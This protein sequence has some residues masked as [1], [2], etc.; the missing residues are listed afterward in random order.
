M[1]PRNLLKYNNKSRI[2]TIGELLVEFVPCNPDGK[3]SQPGE[4]IKTASGSSGIFASA[5]G[6]LGNESGFIGQI[7]KDLLSQFVINVVKKQGV[8][9]QH[10]KV[11]DEGKIG[12]SFVEY[13]ESGRNFQ[14]YRDNSVGSQLDEDGVDAE[15]ISNSAILHYPGMLLELSQSMQ[16]ACIKAV[17]IAKENGVIV[18]FDPNIRKELIQKDGAIDRMKWAVAQADIL[19]PT[20]EEAKFITG[21]EDISKIIR[22]LHAMGPK[23]IAITKDEDGSIISCEDECLDFSGYSIDVIDPTGAG[24]TFSAALLVGIMKEWDLKKIG[25]FA[26][27]AGALVCKKQ[28]T[29]GLA[30]PTYEDTIK[31]MNSNEC[32]TEKI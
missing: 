14:Y 13:T 3:L 11:V 10:I 5:V 6:K 2:I 1:I 25:K 22:K 20:L 24:D 17:K 7:G 23:I 12:L 27:A 29:I 16:R 32:S 15:Y 21:E 28:G 26:N 18:S 31:W 30:I 4:M 9:T 19:S 8:D